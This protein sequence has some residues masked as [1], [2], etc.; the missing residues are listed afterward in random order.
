MSL[1]DEAKSKGL[2]VR[3]CGTMA[4]IVEEGHEPTKPETGNRF[5]LFIE[6]LSPPSAL[7][8]GQPLRTKAGAAVRLKDGRIVPLGAAA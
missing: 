8:T 3:K 6:A 5:V 4:A 7:E 2:L 1:L